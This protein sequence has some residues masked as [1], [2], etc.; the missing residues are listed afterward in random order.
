M[1]GRDSEIVCLRDEIR[2]TAK[3]SWDWNASEGKFILFDF[4]ST[5]EKNH[6]KKFDIKVTD[7]KLV[8]KLTDR[9]WGVSWVSFVGTY[10]SHQ[11]SDSTERPWGQNRRGKTHVPS[12]QGTK[13]RRQHE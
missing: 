11:P 10:G 9:K 3:D 4:F 8:G 6:K 13:S 5:N 7:T 1:E 2:E 12:A